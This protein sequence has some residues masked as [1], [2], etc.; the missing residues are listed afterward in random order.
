MPKDCPF[1]VNTAGLW[2]CQ[3]SGWVLN[4]DIPSVPMGQCPIC[5]RKNAPEERKEEDRW[6]AEHGAGAHLH[7]LIEAWTGEGITAGC[8]CAGH[9]AEMNSR[10][11]DWCGENI[12]RIEKWLLEEVDRRLQVAATARESIPAIERELQAARDSRART[13]CKAGKCVPLV[14]AIDNLTR[15]LAAAQSAASIGWALYVGSKPLPG[16]QKFIR[17]LIHKSI[18]LARRD[19]AAELIGQ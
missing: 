6:L 4:M 16:R 11:P 9:M 19:L 17:H 5:F 2:V 13:I 7:R 18:R 14:K 1:Y 8:E 10:G 3:D 15:R 12:E